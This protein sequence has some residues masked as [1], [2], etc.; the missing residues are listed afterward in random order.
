M[1]MNGT[2]V[3]VQT[4]WY[5]SPAWTSSAKDMYKVNVGLYQGITTDPMIGKNNDS[6][7]TT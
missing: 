6:S 3:M 5:S 7:T 1:R 4:Y 2:L